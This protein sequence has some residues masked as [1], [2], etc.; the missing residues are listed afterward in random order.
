MQILIQLVNYA[1]GE[2]CPESGN[3]YSFITLL[4]VQYNY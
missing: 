2:M 4:R 1:A 3:T